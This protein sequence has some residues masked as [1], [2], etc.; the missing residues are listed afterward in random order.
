MCG[1]VMY[2]G[3][4]LVDLIC[5]TILDEQL[6]HGVSKIKLAINKTYIY[7]RYYI[8]YLADNAD[9]EWEMVL[10]SH[11][12]YIFPGEVCPQF[13]LGDGIW[14]QV[15]SGGGGGGTGGHG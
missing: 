9:I 1:I 2:S 3:R 11:C 14:Q 12:V 5:E 6:M 8:I 7:S 13:I 10:I 15:K 4:S